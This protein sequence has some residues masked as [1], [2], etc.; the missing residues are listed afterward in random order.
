MAGL[1]PAIH[2]FGDRKQRRGYPAFAEHDE[3]ELT[4]N[5]ECRM[6]KLGYKASAEQFAPNRLLAFAECAEQ[7]G[8]DSVFVSDHFHPWKHADG[9]APF[10]PAWLGALGARTGH[11]VMGT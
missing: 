5:E 8:F 7:T 4:A 6:L 11:I 3:G 1:G 10:A 9:H 2:A